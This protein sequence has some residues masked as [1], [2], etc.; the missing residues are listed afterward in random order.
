MPGPGIVVGQQ[1]VG[2]HDFVMFLSWCG[3]NGNSGVG[4]ETWMEVISRPLLS[5]T[6]RVPLLLT[7]S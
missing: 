7:S 6:L 2:P 3:S 4:L 5:T 1:Q